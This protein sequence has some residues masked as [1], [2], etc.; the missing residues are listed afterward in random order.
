MI[1]IQWKSVRTWNVVQLYNK[2]ERKEAEKRREE[3]ERWATRE[4]KVPGQVVRQ[5][6]DRVTLLLY[7]CVVR[8]CPLL[9]RK[10]MIYE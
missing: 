9:Q 3:K 6:Q 7:V 8:R 5:Q 2:G 1:N 10:M 4:D